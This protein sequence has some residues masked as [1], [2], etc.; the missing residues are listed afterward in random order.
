M[1]DLASAP[2]SDIG[3]EPEAAA[4]AAI[5]SQ[6]QRHLNV[7][8]SA[9]T[10]NAKRRDALTALKS[11]LFPTA[12]GPSDAVLGALLSDTLA[13]P[14]LVC[15]EDATESCRSAAL[16]LLQQLA[17]RA[18]A[19]VP[20]LIPY[21]VPVVLA[22]FGDGPSAEPA[23]E[24]RLRLLRFVVTVIEAVMDGSGKDGEDDGV[25]NGAADDRNEN[26]LAAAV[27]AAAVDG[28]GRRPPRQ[29]PG[30]VPYLG[31]L[32]ELAGV[33]VG[34]AF[35]EV[36]KE[37]CALVEQV[38]VACPEHMAV[39]ADPLL[40]TLGV[41]L[42]HKRA[43][44]RTAV[45]SAMEALILTHTT[46]GLEVLLAPDANVFAA[47]LADRS[48]LVR[49]AAVQVVGSILCRYRDRK[50]YEARLLPFLIEG[51]GDDMPVVADLARDWLDAI[52][53]VYEHDNADR[54]QEVIAH[55]DAPVFG[56]P[57]T[58]PPP[59]AATGRPRLGSRMVVRDCLTRVTEAVLN[60]LEDWR[61]ER[62]GAAARA[63]AMLA[64]V[65][66]DGMTMVMP[67]I[68]P[69]VVDRT[70]DDEEPVSK[71]VVFACGILGSY[72]SPEAYVETLGAQAAASSAEVA[73]TR[74]IGAMI[75]LSLLVDGAS[76]AALEPHAERL[77]GLMASRD[78]YDADDVRIQ[79]H[80]MRVVERVVGRIG[81]AVA[82]YGLTL[83]QAL[84]Q[85]QVLR[86]GAEAVVDS[87]VSCE[88]MLAEAL[89][90]SRTEL[91]D[92]YFDAALDS[93][94]AT[95]PSWTSASFELAYLA[96]LLERAGRVAA[97]RG[98]RLVP[99]FVDLA[100][101]K[102]KPEFR[103]SVF[104]IMGV[105]LGTSGG[106]LG[107]ACL[108]DLL[109]LAVLPNLVWAAGGEV[110]AMRTRACAAVVAAVEAGDDVFGAETALAVATQWTTVIASCL[111]DRLPATR[112]GMCKIVAALMERGGDALDLALAEGLGEQLVGRLDD[113]DDAV[114]VVALGGLASYL[115]I[116][117]ERLDADAL[118][119]LVDVILVHM[120]DTNAPVRD[121]ALGALTQASG[122][123]A[124]VVAAR[125]G[126]VRDRHRN[127]DY[128]DRLIGGSLS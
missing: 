90:G 99:L 19:R 16:S 35:H 6:V 79:A 45:L 28:Q 112:L 91:Y 127:P 69:V 51:L 59:F 128:C 117:A 7:L 4:V 107:A 13:K 29:T 42:A 41:A 120:D 101:P 124:D 110:A 65:A 50:S 1:A 119:A 85:L 98:D 24:I 10:T 71:A 20:A 70:L 73:E 62:R 103:S 58:L 95:V 121:G 57:E 105:V 17:A 80:R 5:T 63:L 116:W 12:D 93:V 44:V 43:R 118:E 22:R 61:G 78:M 83:F 94:A 75:A 87:A 113:A 8:A 47:S 64:V 33:S 40:H 34:D 68:L 67:R 72:V 86:E 115:A 88:G 122:K 21:L 89:G 102:R 66:E 48:P 25:D 55:G 27:V 37:A 52:G 109:N 92:R 114:R 39:H 54:I 97:A 53:A 11:A 104:D 111:D 123:A 74:Q 26:S 60:N 126:M 77:V 46:S 2:A 82:P 81:A 36:R 76:G 15:L 3:A 84:L 125:A 96:K 23:E 30:L 14:L 49:K 32:V 38:A 106:D 108:A 100:G 9:E 56:S 18:P 31:D